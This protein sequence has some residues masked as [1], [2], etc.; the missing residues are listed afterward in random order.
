M[1]RD[2]NHS[3]Y[4]H[5][6]TMRYETTADWRFYYH[7]GG[8]KKGD[9]RKDTFLTWDVVRWILEKGGQRDPLD[10]ILPSHWRE[11]CKGLGQNCT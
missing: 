11:A 5:A 9:P 6:Q 7:G 4:W 10:E 3:R 8:L 2:L 1:T